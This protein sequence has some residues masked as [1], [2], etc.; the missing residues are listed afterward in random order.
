MP[1]L[2]TFQTLLNLDG[3]ERANAYNEMTNCITLHEFLIEIK[4]HPNH[5]RRHD[6]RSILYEI[7]NRIKGYQWRRLTPISTAPPPHTVPGTERQFKFEPSPAETENLWNN[8]AV[9]QTIPFTA[10][11]LGQ[12]APRIRGLRCPPPALKPRHPTP[13]TP[14]IP[15]DNEI[16]TANLE[17]RV[18]NMSI[19]AEAGLNTLMSFGELS[20]VL[21][22]SGPEIYLY[23]SPLHDTYLPM[24]EE[25]PFLMGPVIDQT[26]PE[27]QNMDTWPDLDIIDERVA[28]DNDPMSRIGRYHYLYILFSR[29]RELVT[30]PQV[31]RC[32]VIVFRAPPGNY[33]P[34]SNDELANELLPTSDESRFQVLLFSIYYPHN[35]GVAIA[36]VLTNIS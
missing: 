10:G 15:L 23:D 13:D 16:W 29:V 11:G 28:P 6:A 2:V 7:D 36:C 25:S 30:H 12:I 35:V 34:Y 1:L 21:G 3:Q 31:A 4:D 26:N 33:G 5:S 9:F 20:D 14:F 8:E 22:R 32:F 24:P 19:T 27:L 17:S 18:D